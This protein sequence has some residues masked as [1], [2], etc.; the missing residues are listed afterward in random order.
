MS[1]SL[2]RKNEPNPEQKVS[3]GRRRESEDSADDDTGERVARRHV[4]RR[5]VII[6]GDRSNALY[7]RRPN[8][9]PIPGLVVFRVDMG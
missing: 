5:F 4:V 1:N 8:R 9:L 6:H 2:R 3:A 7:A